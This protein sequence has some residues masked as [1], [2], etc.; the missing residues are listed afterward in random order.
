M[1]GAWADTNTNVSLSDGTLTI[2][3]TAPGTLANYSFSDAEKAATSLV[4]EGK[5]NAADLQAIQTSGNNFRFTSVDLSQAKT[6]DNYNYSGQLTNGAVSGYEWFK[7]EA[8]GS[9]ST[10][11][12]VGGTLYQTSVELKKKWVSGGDASWD[13]NVYTESELEGIKE[14]IP[15]GTYVWVVSEPAKYKYYKKKDQY[16]E[17]V[18]S[19]SEAKKANVKSN[20]IGTLLNKYNVDDVVWC[21]DE[22][23][24]NYTSYGLVEEVASK[25]W[26]AVTDKDNAP[27]SYVYTT[28][29][30][31]NANDGEYAVVGG[32]E[33]VN[34]GTSWV[35][36]TEARTIVNMSLLKFT[37]W[38]GSLQ[39]AVCPNGVSVSD[40]STDILQNCSNLTS[41]TFNDKTLASVSSGTTSVQAISVSDFQAVQTILNNASLSNISWTSNYIRYNSEGYYDVH[42]T[43]PGNFSYFY[44]APG[45]SYADRSRF[46]FDNECYVNKDDLLC[47][48]NEKNKKYYVDLFNITNG[49]NTPMKIDNYL[50]EEDNDNADNIDMVMEAAVADMVANG[51]QARGIILP[52]NTGSGTTKVE[53][54]NK[55]GLPTFTEYAAYY[56]NSQK[57]AAIHVY[58]IF[59]FYDEK[60]PIKKDDGTG[61][62]TG[63]QPNF[64]IA[65]GHVLIHEEIA[66]GAKIYMVG[67]NN[68]NKL[69]LKDVIPDG[70]TEIVLAGDE[71]VKANHTNLADIYVKTVNPGD[72]DAAVKGT[73]VKGTPCDELIIEGPVKAEDIAAVNDFS[74][75]EVAGPITYNLAEAKVSDPGITQEMLSALTNSKIEYIILPVGAQK[76]VV[77]DYADLANLKCVISS[78]VKTKEG[79]KALAAYVKVAGSLAEA[80]KYATKSVLAEDAV[81]LTTVM[82][83]GKLTAN[84]ITGDDKGGLCGENG[85]IKSLDLTDAVFVSVN[86]A[87]EEVVDC[88]QMKFD[89]YRGA[90]KAL[91]SILL[92]RDKRMNTIPVSCFE[93]LPNL[94]DI[95]I[96]INYTRLEGEAFRETNLKHLTTTDAKGLEIDKGDYTYILPKNLAYIGKNCFATQ[97]KLVTDVFVQ[98]INAPKC[99]S[100]AFSSEMTWGDGGFDI[101]GASTNGVYCRDIFKNGTNVI[102]VLHFPAQAETGLSDADYDAKASLYTD[103]TRVYTKKDQTGAVDANGDPLFWPIES[104]FKRSYH[105]AQAGVLWLDEGWLP[106]QASGDNPGE[107]YTVKE[108]GSTNK[109]ETCNFKDYVG[110]HEFVLA[111]AA[112]MPQ[113]E[114]VDENEKIVREYESDGWHTFCI[115]FD[116]TEEEVVEMMGVPKSEGNIV[117]KL[118]GK[119]VS[120]NELPEIHTLKHVTRQWNP[121]N[122]HGII[123]MVLSIPLVKEEN[124]KKMGF[125]PKYCRA[126][127]IDK[128]I[129]RNGHENVGETEVNETNGYIGTTPVIL[130]AGYP[131]LIKSYKRK[132]ESRPYLG[133]YVMTHFDFPEDHSSVKMVDATGEHITSRHHNNCWI[134]LIKSSDKDNNPHLTAVPAGASID[135]LK[136]IEKDANKHDMEA[137]FAIPYEGHRFKASILNVDGTF[138]EYDKEHIYS[139]Q[140]NYWKQPL[141]LNCYYLYTKSAP[142]KWYYYKTYSNSYLWHPYTCILGVGL[143]ERPDD[144]TDGGTNIL[145]PIAWDA[146]GSPIFKR[147]FQLA[148]TDEIDDSFPGT[149]HAR[150]IRIV[151]DDAVVELGEDGQQ[152]TAIES[153]DGQRL[154]SATGKVYNLRGQ[155]V[156]TSTDGLPKGLYIVNGRKIVVD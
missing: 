114:V 141:P 10:K 34:A 18:S 54:A 7:T 41:V 118:D 126:D 1:T 104:E 17:E 99:E 31:C 56:R 72:F 53:K 45:S 111:S 107:L 29:P 74:S 129:M 150:E 100:G 146:N 149:S 55:D 33:Y 139:F 19:T 110:W 15:S 52:Y 93:Q 125:F 71:M 137:R 95:C 130:R 37:Y 127:D 140:G 57:V 154:S 135:R 62:G 88:S 86:Q 6:V 32:T 66:T 156:G 147:K 78:D 65:A 80:R 76:P 49:E 21:Y 79:E 85:T 23:N 5:F 136:G 97:S 42:V 16:W 59:T 75:S 106:L 122:N 128:T 108:K 51:Y 84:D 26:N 61:A 90:G 152:A 14:T 3:T 30:E 46:V 123:Q 144:G 60:S 131:Y 20:A 155:Q 50:T 87:G 117:N 64:E 142:H 81:G 132:D 11:A 35:A 109:L 8:T 83:S 4:L 38:S 105:Q 25:S 101:T 102:A 115:P 92:P 73:G 151:F 2:T 120:D 47:I 113:D 9:N 119:V 112:F 44:N 94:T 36:A 77:G 48:L 124:G 91:A 69:T 153:L 70:K 82:L 138:Q 13:A 145:D 116:M 121:N 28:L 98:S 67:T 103:L 58:D 143:D 96:P 24:N 39:T 63:A 133:Q 27:L 43:A 40:L 68:R 134:D 89:S 22:N 12:I 148:Y